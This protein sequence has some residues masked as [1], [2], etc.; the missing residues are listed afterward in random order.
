MAP[1][2]AQVCGGV[3]VTFAAE[4]CELGRGMFGERRPSAH[5]I[6]A[7][8]ELNGVVRRLHLG[9]IVSGRAAAV[10]PIWPAQLLEDSEHNTNSVVGQSDQ[11]AA[12]MYGRV[13]AVRT[14]GRKGKR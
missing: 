9:D 2:T 14:H 5:R 6:M 4:R 13:P 3:R 12:G 10:A 1:V 7:A 8:R 11:G